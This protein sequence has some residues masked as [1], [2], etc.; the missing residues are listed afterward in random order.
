ML[1]LKETLG[2][3][4]WLPNVHMHFTGC[5]GAGVMANSCRVQQLVVV[6]FGL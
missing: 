1:T 6:P 5:V 3:H 2:Y 4:Q